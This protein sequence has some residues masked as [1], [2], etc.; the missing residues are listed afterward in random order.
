[1]LSGCHTKLVFTVIDTVR[2]FTIDRKIFANKAQVNEDRTR[3]TTGNHFHILHLAQV[4]IVRAVR[5]HD[6]APRIAHKVIIRTERHL[7]DG[8]VLVINIGVAH[9]IVNVLVK[10]R[11]VAMPNKFTLMLVILIFNVRSYI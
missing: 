7:K 4:V 1:M 2:S 11:I 8:Q 3:I 10:L 5:A 6:T 9:I